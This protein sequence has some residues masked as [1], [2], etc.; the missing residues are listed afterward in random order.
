MK[1]KSKLALIPLLLQ[2]HQTNSEC[3]NPDNVCE[4]S[5]PSKRPLPGCTTFAECDAILN[6]VTTY[7]TCTAGTLFDTLMGICNWDYLTFCNVKTCAPTPS[8]T[9]APTTQNP[10]LN[11]TGRPSSEFIVVYSMSV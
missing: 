2:L 7:Q 3:V 8:P 9:V 5:G 6:T 11:P 10:T 1:P 4:G